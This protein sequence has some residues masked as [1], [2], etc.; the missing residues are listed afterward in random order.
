[1][2][3]EKNMM[4]TISSSLSLGDGWRVENVTFDEKSGEFHI[5]VVPASHEKFTCPVCGRICRSYDREESERVW[6]HIDM[7]EYRSFV[8]CRRPRV[9]CAFCGVRV[10]SVPFARKGSRY[11]LSF[12]G[13]A[14]ILTKAMPNDRVRKRLGISN[15]SLS[16]LC[17][18]SKESPPTENKHE[19]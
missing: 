19:I 14:V 6:R 16:Y 10:I 1:M 3:D 9:S 2:N 11:T 5:F 4:D 7:L 13:A 15:T 8:H 12:E 18:A 17:G